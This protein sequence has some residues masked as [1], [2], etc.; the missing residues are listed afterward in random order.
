MR[1]K[2][3]HGRFSEI[4]H[5]FLFRSPNGTNKSEYRTNIPDRGLNDE[6]VFTKIGVNIEVNSQK[7]SHHDIYMLYYYS[8]LKSAKQ[9]EF[10]SSAKLLYKNM[11]KCEF[12]FFFVKVLEDKAF[13]CGHWYNCFRLYGDVSSGFQSHSGQPYSRLMGCLCAICSL[14]FTSGVTPANLLVASMTAATH[15]MTPGRCSTDR[16]MPARHKCEFLDKSVQRGN[17]FMNINLLLFSDSQTLKIITYDFTFST[18][19]EI[20]SRQRFGKVKNCQWPPYT[21][22]ATMSINLTQTPFRIPE[23]V[24]V[25][26]FCQFLYANKECIPVV[27]VSFAEVAVSGGGVCPGRGCTPPLGQNYWHTLL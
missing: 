18:S 3:F 15:S 7:L 11:Y 16:A 25:V 8:S 6:T 9:A 24:S 1:K 17:V 19:T 2:T 13:L 27:C 14:R 22:D 10:S 4:I 26:H 5:F 20:S 23:S 21:L 12:L